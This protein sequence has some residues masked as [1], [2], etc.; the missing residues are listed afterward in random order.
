MLGQ[1]IQEVRISR[2]VVATIVVK[3]LPRLLTLA[4]C[5]I[6][7]YLNRQSAILV[8]LGSLMSIPMA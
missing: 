8:L 6:A 3:I 4:P 1:L 7:E 2:A 5:T